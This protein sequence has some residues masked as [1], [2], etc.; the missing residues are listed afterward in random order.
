MNTVKQI[1]VL[2]STDAYILRGKSGWAVHDDEQYGLW[3]GY[4]EC[5]DNTYYFALN[6]EMN[7]DQAHL[8]QRIV[9]DVFQ[10]KGILPK[11]VV[12]K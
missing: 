2:D 1:M 4:I 9:L 5:P 12:W 8:R 7:D 11:D 6:I 3:V 10:S